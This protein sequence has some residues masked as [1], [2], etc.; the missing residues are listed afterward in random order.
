MTPREIAIARAF[1]NVS[2]PPATAAKRFARNMIAHMEHAPQV[3]L[4]AKQAA[5]MAKIA[6]RFRR[7]MPAHL[8][9]PIVDDG[10]E[11]AAEGHE[12]A[13]AKPIERPLSARDVA[14]LA[15][16]ARRK[17]EAAQRAAVQAAETNARPELPL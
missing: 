5:Y 17:A 6:H 9:H 10:S 13:G 8:A 7:Q 2:F 16:E 11:A 3:P 14:K 1:R 4:T 15:Q 12:R